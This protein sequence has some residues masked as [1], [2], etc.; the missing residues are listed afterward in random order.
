MGKQQEER[1]KKIQNHKREADKERTGGERERATGWMDAHVLNGSNRDTGAFRKFT[2]ISQQNN[3][4][5]IV[6]TLFN[7]LRP[8]LMQ[9]C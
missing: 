3:T 5:Y 2:V 8:R 1:H 6:Y 7:V 9:L 4:D